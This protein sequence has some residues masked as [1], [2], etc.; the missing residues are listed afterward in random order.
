MD[1]SVDRQR[2]RDRD[3]TGGLRRGLESH[4]LMAAP[5]PE[6]LAVWRSFLMAQSLIER[7]LTSALGEERDLPL[8]WF[9]VLN[10][11][12]SEGG[13]VRV[14]DLAEHLVVSPSSLSRQLG[15]M[16]DE[17]LVRRDRGT[18]DDQ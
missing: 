18:P 10:A 5:D 1:A 2:T 8:E 17:G 13:K 3:R 14:M 6:R 4:G 11:L 12:Q 15:R 9:E 16:E 7:T